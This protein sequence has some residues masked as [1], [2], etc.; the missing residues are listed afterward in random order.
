ML[1][2]V[3]A[4]ES[5]QPMDMIRV[6]LPVSDKNFACLNSRDETQM[7]ATSAGAR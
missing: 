3:Q 5:G 6:V 4:V 1:L 7:F 2:A